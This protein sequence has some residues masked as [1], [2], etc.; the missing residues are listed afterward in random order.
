MKRLFVFLMILVMAAILPSC[1]RETGYSD[2]IPTEKEAE[3]AE[4]ETVPTG[5]MSGI[6]LLRTHCLLSRSA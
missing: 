3:P 4:T 5:R 2:P 6:D 1:S